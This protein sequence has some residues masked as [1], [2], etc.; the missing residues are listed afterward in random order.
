MYSAT[1]LS[2]L[3][4]VSPQFV[5]DAPSTKVVDFDMLLTIHYLGIGETPIDHKLWQ[6]YFVEF[7]KKMPA[8]EITGDHVQVQSLY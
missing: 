2:F 8:G 5:R 4:T 3:P 7:V 6:N 1:D